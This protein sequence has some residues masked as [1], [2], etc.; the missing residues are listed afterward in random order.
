[1]ITELPIPWNLTFWR[2]SDFLFVY[3]VKNPD[4][5]PINNTGWQVDMDVRLLPDTTPIVRL[6][7]VTGEI[8][9]AGVT[10]WVTA[11]LPKVAIATYPEGEFRYDIHETY[12]DG[13][14]DYRFRGTV[15]VERMVTHA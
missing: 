8:T 7:T 2:D 13:T 9:L 14:D 4:G 5:T 12:T 11:R 10:G 15:T 3:R 1:M 6:S